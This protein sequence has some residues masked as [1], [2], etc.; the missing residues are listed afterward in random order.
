MGVSAYKFGL[1]FF[2]HHMN[3]LFFKHC[4]GYSESLLRREA[5][6]KGWFVMGILF[7]VGEHNMKH[8]TRR[9]KLP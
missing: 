1:S 4:H 3:I 6:K 5:G 9:N 2:L 8:A 7:L